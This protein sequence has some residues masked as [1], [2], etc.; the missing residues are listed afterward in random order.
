MERRLLQSKFGKCSTKSRRLTTSSDNWK[1][2]LT[3]QRREERS[4]FLPM[5]PEKTLGGETIAWVRIPTMRCPDCDGCGAFVEGRVGHL[6]TSIGESYWDARRKTKAAGWLTT[7]RAY[8]RDIHYCNECADKPQKPIK[9]P[10]RPKKCQECRDVT[11]AEKTDT[12]PRMNMGWCR[13]AVCGWRR[14][15]WKYKS[16]TL[17][18]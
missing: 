6:A 1:C 17:D 10:A 12:R 8:R 18:S 13:C 16:E 14:K 9:N 4:I 15:L 5:H 11:R 7:E 2:G 3:M